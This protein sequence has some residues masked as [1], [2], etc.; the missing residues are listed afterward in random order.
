V[1]RVSVANV[2]CA[3]LRSWLEGDLV[4]RNR[5]PAVVGPRDG[6]CHLANGHNVRGRSR[7]SSV[8]NSL[9]LCIRELCREAWGPLALKRNGRRGCG[10][11]HWRENLEIHI[12]AQ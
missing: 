1:R 11:F 10:R 7:Y 5:T 8:V 2:A 12:S 4:D 3:S 9:A 6:P